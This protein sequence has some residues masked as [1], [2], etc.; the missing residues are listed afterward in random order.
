MPARRASASHNIASTSRVHRSNGSN[1]SISAQ[2]PI[3]QPSNLP[4]A[5]STNIPAS[6]QQKVVQVLINRLKNK[7]PCN[8]G[9]SLTELEADDAM[10]QT[11]EALVDLSRDS[12]D[13]ISLALTE[14]LDK[15]AKQIESAGF[16]GID[17]LQSQLFL[18]K[19][20]SLAMASRWGSRAEETRPNS[21]GSK[22]GAGSKP[23][24][25]DTSVPTPGRGRHASSEQLSNSATLVE[26]PA[27]DD[28]CARYIISV[29]VLL[30]RQAAPRKHRLTSAASMSF[31]A[32]FQDF[33]SVE[34][35][36]FSVTD[37]ALVTLPPPIVSGAPP[38]SMNRA[39]HPSSTSL[40]S[41]GVTSSIS[42]RLPQHS[43]A[44]EKT[45]FLV[46][47][48]VLSLHSSIAKYTGRIV[49]HL[50]ASNW[51]VV[52]SRIRQRIHTLA[53][54]AEPEPDTVDLQLITYSAL[55]RSKLVQSLQE[56]SSLL[57]N[58][59]K[60]AQI[61]VSIALRTAIWNWIELCPDEYND[62]LQYHR[63]LEG[64]PERVF[65]LL[66]DLQENSRDKAGA[67]PTLAVLLCISHDRLKGEF[68]SALGHK[69]PYRK[70]DRNITDLIIRNL[71]YASKYSEVAIVCAV[72]ICRA[73]SRV[74]PHA[75][76]ENEAPLISTAFD[77]AHELKVR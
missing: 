11:V 5:S 41:A 25:P 66:F 4:Y 14:Q 75:D 2:S 30:L 70:Q 21:P 9:I 13:M 46:A 56:L 19:V 59:K 73:A 44:Y 8:S 40:N 28:N 34:S 58:L 33:E 7:L 51:A 74:R 68:E 6:P 57:M 72:D 39:K 22:R 3:V 61:P 53:S 69:G 38:R 45:S 12:L 43:V 17:I 50:S 64:A 47:K 15:L 36:E 10:Q 20:L 55:D 18:L 32:S 24:T 37:E 1:H 54:S 48:S 71:P 27:L 63:R 52:L 62:A 77:I 49:Y 31:D 16:R 67:W 60:D 35:H 76:S 23:T 29:M 65:D 26:P 42:S